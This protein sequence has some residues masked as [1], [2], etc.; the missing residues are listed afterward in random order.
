[1]DFNFGKSAKSLAKNSFYNIYFNLPCDIDFCLRKYFD[2]LI[3][4][5]SVYIYFRKDYN[6]EKNIF[7]FVLP[8]L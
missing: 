4:Y 1:M 5:S 2:E 3:S 6:I 8:D 7:S